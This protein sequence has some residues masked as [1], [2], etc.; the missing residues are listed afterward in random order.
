MDFF[1]CPVCKEKLYAQNKSLVCSNNHTFDIAK[2]GY[3]N[4]LL[5]KQ[6]GKNVHGD[7]KLMVRARRDFLSKGYYSRLLTGLS[8]T[9]KRYFKN[10]CTILDAGCG[11]GYYTNGVYEFLAA[12]NS[13]VNIYGVDIS[14]IALEYAAKKC[15]DVKYAVGS[16]FNIPAANESCDIL[17]TLFA[18][19]CREEFERVLKKDGILIMVIP[20]ERHLWGLKLAVYDTPYLNDVKD[21]VIKG[22]KLLE[23]EKITYEMIIDNNQDIQNLFSMTPYYYKTGKK[24]QER[25]ANLENLKTEAEFE[26]L[27][28]KIERN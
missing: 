1:I 3:V 22:F 7:N 18:P 4:L 16:I 12:E 9:V 15:K 8:E 23:R 13:D 28:Y 20:S 5:S 19:F 6:A 21:Y 26:I 24:E 27:T 25:L 11:E 2:S 14:K 10:S 17:M